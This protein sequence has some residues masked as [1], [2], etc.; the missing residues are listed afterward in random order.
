M[1]LGRTR[2]YTLSLARQGRDHKSS[3][4][5][6]QPRLSVPS[7]LFL[8]IS[9]A[10]TA[11][12]RPSSPSPPHNRAPQHPNE[13]SQ[14]PPF[15]RPTTSYQPMSSPCRF[16]APTYPSSRRPILG[17]ARLRSTRPPP[18]VLKR[19]NRDGEPSVEAEPAEEYGAGILADEGS[20]ELT[21][22]IK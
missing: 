10:D 11:S 5:L 9:L 18:S 1:G 6:P 2:P 20:K 3:I 17:S 19:G 4:P 7:T 13:K 8:F 14:Y 15:A 12:H 16:H 22:M 21:T